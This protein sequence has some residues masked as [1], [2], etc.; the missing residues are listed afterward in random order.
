MTSSVRKIVGQVKSLSRDDKE[1]FLTWLADFELEH[2]DEWDQQLQ[3]DS[4][5]GGR[6]EGTLE[7]VRKDITQGRTKPLDEVIDNS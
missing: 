4:Q 6:L 5:P 3:R 2:S 7:R 1:E